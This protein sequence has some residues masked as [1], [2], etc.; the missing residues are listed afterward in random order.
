MTRADV[1]A[2]LPELELALE[3]ATLRTGWLFVS[4]AGPERP[5]RDGLHFSGA[6]AKAIGERTAQAVLLVVG[7]HP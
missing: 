4:L 7:E 3:E 2:Q 1:A 5:G 6:A